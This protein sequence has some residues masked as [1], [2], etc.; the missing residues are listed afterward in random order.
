MKLKTLRQQ[1]KMKLK[2]IAGLLNVS[3]QAIWKHE[4][5]GIKSITTAKKYAAALGV[6]WQD[7]ID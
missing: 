5:Q 7:L 1:K 6:D 3:P 2:Q 4:K